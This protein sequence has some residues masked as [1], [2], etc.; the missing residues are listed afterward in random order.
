MRSKIYSRQ[1]HFTILW[2]RKWKEFMKKLLKSLAIFF[3]TPNIIVY[4][5]LETLKILTT[6]LM[7]N[8]NKV[9]A[10]LMISN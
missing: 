8:S 9:E 1:M 6:I 10:Y 7:K 2:S 5:V 4:M 3:Q